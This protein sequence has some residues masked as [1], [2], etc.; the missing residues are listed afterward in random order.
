MAE[1]PAPSRHARKLQASGIGLQVGEH[2]FTAIKFHHNRPA[3]YNTIVMAA[4]FVGNALR[5]SPD[6]SPHAT[7]PMASRVGRCG[8]GLLAITDLHLLLYRRRG[9]GYRP[10]EAFWAAEVGSITPAKVH[11]ARALEI[12]FA[13]GSRCELDAETARARKHLFEVLDALRATRV[14]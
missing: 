6:R 8:N 1:F 13:D 3:D 10:D 9:F 7:P 5:K 11:L 14:S 4:R 2:V 12:V